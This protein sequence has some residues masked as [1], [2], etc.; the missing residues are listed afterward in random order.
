MTISPTEPRDEMISYA[1]NFED[2]ILNRI[3]ANQHSGF[4]VDIGACHPIY[5]SVTQHFYLRGWRGVNIEPQP[6]LFAE[7]QRERPR[8]INLSLCV[9]SQPSQQILYVTEDKGTSTLDSGLANKYQGAGR[10][11]Q[12]IVVDVVPL[13]EI[14]HTHIGTQPVDFLKIDV[15]GF[16]KQVL[17]G[18]DFYVIAPKI[19]MVEAVSP[20]SQ[21]PTHSE[22]EYLISEHYCFF[23]FDGLNRFY[24]RKNFALSLPYNATPPN[25]FDRFKSHSQQLAEQANYNLTNKL[26]ANQIEINNFKVLLQQKDHALQH[27][28]ES[29]CDLQKETE[30]L[31]KMLE[32]KDAALQDAAAAY[33]SLKEFDEKLKDQMAGLENRTS[34]QA[35]NSGTGQY[36]QL[37]EKSKTHITTLEQLISQKNPAILDATEAYKALLHHFDKLQSELQHL[38]KTKEKSAAPDQDCN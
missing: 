32:Q 5:D 21:I 16:E 31:K 22:W 11:I 8:D 23:Y 36:R 2:V 37:L 30:K 3:F 6:T 24:H 14:W 15:E 4:Y 38:R 19:L 13:N 20:D 1:Q 27:A 17:L 18:A 34:T 10:I 29:Y 25:V 12:E 35:D 9:G 7:L 26:D 28:A 33:N